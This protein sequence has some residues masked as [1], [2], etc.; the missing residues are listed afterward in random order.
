MF[1]RSAASGATIKNERRIA[2][3][4]YHSNQFKFDLAL[5]RPATRTITHARRAKRF[6][7]L[8]SASGEAR[9]LRSLVD[10]LISALD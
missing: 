7:E 3:R 10:K 8:A 9:A 2:R 6:I 4:S 5:P 1:H